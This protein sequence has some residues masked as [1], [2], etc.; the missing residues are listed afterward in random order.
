MSPA[1]A[2]SVPNM[3]VPANPQHVQ[4]ARQYLAKAGGK[5]RRARELAA[6]D[7]YKF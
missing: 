5:K 6:Q 2:T 1:G 4:I 3:L 7:G